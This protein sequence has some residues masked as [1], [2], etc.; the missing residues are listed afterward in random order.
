M[1]YPIWNK[2]RSCIYKTNKSYGAKDIGEVDVYVGSSEDNSHHLITHYTTRI[3]KYSKE[4]KQDVVV[5]RFGVELP[6]GNRIILATKTFSI[7]GGKAKELLDSKEIH[8][9]I[10]GINIKDK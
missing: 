5:F 2:V 8:K 9:N 3:V 4:F 7:L 10:K 6:S 1:N